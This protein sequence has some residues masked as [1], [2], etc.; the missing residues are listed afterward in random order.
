MINELKINL[1]ADKFSGAAR[2]L[3]H[4]QPIIGNNLEMHQAAEVEFP[5]MRERIDSDAELSDKQ[6]NFAKQRFTSLQYS[7][8]TAGSFVDAATGQELL[9]D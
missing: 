8:G 3:K 2:V 9:P 7:S 6:K 5:E 1:P 4:R